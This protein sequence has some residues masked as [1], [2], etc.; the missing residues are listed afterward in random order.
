MRVESSVTS[1]SW[2]PSAASA[3]MTRIPFEAGVTHCD[4]PPPDEWSDLDSV[5]GPEGARFA[6][7]LRAW[8]A[9]SD[10]PAR[11]LT[12]LVWS[13]RAILGLDHEPSRSVWC[14]W[15]DRGPD[16]VALHGLLPWCLFCVPG[17]R[18]R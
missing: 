7:D 12:N 11:A 13:N 8:K 14:L 10:S 9:S 16:G 6:N 4:D 1:I 5:L 2:I 17:A 18:S 15:A 3:D